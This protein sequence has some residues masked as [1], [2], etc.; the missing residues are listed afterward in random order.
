MTDKDVPDYAIVNKDQ[1]GN[2]PTSFSMCTSLFFAEKLDHP[3]K[4]MYFT[5]LR[6]DGAPFFAFYDA[7]EEKMHIQYTAF[8]VHMAYKLGHNKFK[9]SF[10]HWDHHCVGI[11]TVSGHVTSVK[12]GHVMFDGILDA[13]KNNTAL[14]PKSLKWTLILGKWTEQGNVWMTC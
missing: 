10:N 11:D 1:T 6:E 12:Q 5:L 9:L 4:Q 7:S 14:Q 2:L 13:M 3:A 8:I